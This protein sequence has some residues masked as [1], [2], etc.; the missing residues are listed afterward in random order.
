MAKWKEVP[1]GIE[2]DLVNEPPHYTTS[3]IECID[4]MKA[5]ADAISKTPKSF[6]VS[7]FQAH[8]WLTIIKY[9]WR[10]PTKYNPLED[11]K[12]ARWYLDKLITSIEGEDNGK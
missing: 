10:W 7:L 8:L 11:L 6:S 4:A 3:N 5:M 2:A 1:L 9:M 12:K